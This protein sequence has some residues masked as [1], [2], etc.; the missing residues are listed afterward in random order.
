MILCGRGRRLNP[1]EMPPYAVGWRNFFG[2]TG[3]SLT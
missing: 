3:P 1:G 2:Y